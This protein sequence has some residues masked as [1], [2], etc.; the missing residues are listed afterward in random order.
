M[1][2]PSIASGVYDLVKQADARPIVV[3]GDSHAFWAN[4]LHDASGRRVACEF[5]GTSI[6][7]PG[8]G[9]AIKSFDIGAVFAKVS[10]E[11]VFN[12]QASKGFVLLT[13][14]RDAARGD[15]MAVSTIVSR[16]FTT[17][18][19]K[20]FEVTPQGKGLSGFREIEA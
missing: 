3:S 19:V 6:T 14:T 5:G 11:V 12:D 4:E 15:L 18:T 13:L 10:P 7:S 9:D 20:S 2:I 16:I 17:R 1:D 8:G